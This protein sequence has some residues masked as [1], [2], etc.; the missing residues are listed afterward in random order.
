MVQ[1][2]KI[3]LLMIMLNPTKSH[4]PTV[5][6]VGSATQLSIQQPKQSINYRSK[7]SGSGL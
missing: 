5:D 6:M 7:Y 4:H 2:L 1:H 3:Y